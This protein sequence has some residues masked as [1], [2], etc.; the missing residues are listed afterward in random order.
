[1]NISV[2]SQPAP[3]IASV[4][5][6][7]DSEPLEF[8]CVKLEDLEVATL[9]RLD[10]LLLKIFSRNLGLQSVLEDVNM[11]A[12]QDIMSS[13]DLESGGI[14]KLKGPHR[15]IICRISPPIF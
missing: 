15:R 14:R 7:D 1:L 6:E 5:N 9:A 13:L 8:A 2:V 12:L 4:E 3:P 11:S 10:D